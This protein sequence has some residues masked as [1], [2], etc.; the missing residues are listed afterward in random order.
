MEKLERVKFT[1]EVEKGEDWLRVDIG[2]DIHWEIRKGPA[3]S[4]SR[5][6]LTL[7]Y[8]H[9]KFRKPYIAALRMLLDEVCDVITK[10]QGILE[11]ELGVKLE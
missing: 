10:A 8:E 3:A 1:I 9:P 6:G 4:V 5:N 7:A 2:D 11:T